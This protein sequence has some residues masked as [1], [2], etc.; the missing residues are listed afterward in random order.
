MV[1]CGLML[2]IFDGFNVVCLIFSY[3]LIIVKRWNEWN[4]EV[5]KG[6]MNEKRW[7]VNMIYFVLII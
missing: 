2:F 3:F 4:L 7:E 6:I 1:D 5:Y